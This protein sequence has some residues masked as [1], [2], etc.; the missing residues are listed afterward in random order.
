MSH[1]SHSDPETI[2]G[3][4]QGFFLLLAFLLLKALFEALQCPFLGA[5]GLFHVN[6]RG[7][8]GRLGEDGD[9]VVEGLK[10]AA[11]RRK[12]HVAALEV[13]VFVGRFC[14]DDE[15]AHA[16]RRNQ[17]GVALPDLKRALDARGSHPIR[18]C[19]ERTPIRRNNVNFKFV[20]HDSGE[21]VRMHSAKE[22]RTVEADRSP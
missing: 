18:G 10:K 9:L 8:F 13:G 22:R 11:A 3:T 1:V 20:G 4:L 2:A 7:R 17:R 16:K 6:L 12:H 14:S 21:N 5:F 19:L 15:G